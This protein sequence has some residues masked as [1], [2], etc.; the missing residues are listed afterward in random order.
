[1]AARPHH[2]AATDVGTPPEPAD[3]VRRVADAVKPRLRGW[4]HTGTAPLA[5]V[6]G[7]V[8]VALAPTTAGKVSTAVFALSAVVLFGCSAVYHRGTWSPRAAAVLRRLDH[9]NIF[10]L[11]AGTYTPLAVLLLD[12][13][14]ATV[15]LVVVWTGAAFG[16]AARLVWLNAPR[17]VYVP[18]YMALGWVAVGFMPQFWATGGPAVVWLVAGGGLAYTLGALVYALKRPN[19]SPRWFGFHEIFH[20]GT[21]VG[22]A[23]HYVA[24]FLAAS[25]A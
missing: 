18:I 6:A 3:A 5:L 21:V 25:Q 22:F 17:W 2:D 4:L 12:R 7:V 8:L 11:I 15:L 23:C 19:P 10:L 14:T 13:S 24:V 20:V 1:M 9:S 16:I